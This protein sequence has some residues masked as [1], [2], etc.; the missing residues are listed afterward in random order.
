MCSDMGI[1][2]MQGYSLPN[3]SLDTSPTHATYP[4]VLY[5]PWNFYKATAYFVCFQ[6]VK[7]FEMSLAHLQNQEELL[8]T[9]LAKKT[10]ANSQLHQKR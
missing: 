5:E 2:D 8:T 10:K 4:I 6:S 9:E 7:K 3:T 1:L